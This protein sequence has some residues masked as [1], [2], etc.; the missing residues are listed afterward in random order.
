MSAGA[1]SYS[2]AAVIV[3]GVGVMTYAMRAS[4][5]V[6][7]GDRQLPDA[8]ERSLRYV[9]PSVLAALAINLAAGSSDGGI[10]ITWVEVAALVAAVLVAVRF[11]HLVAV[12]AAGMAVLWLGAAVGW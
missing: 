3:A 10:S 1:L 4:V 8:V 12:L 9:G 6:A 11:K 5:I 2:A 7:L